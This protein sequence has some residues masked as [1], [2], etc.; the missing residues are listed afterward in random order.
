MTLFETFDGNKDV[1]R[2][3]SKEDYYHIK[4]KFSKITKK[5]ETET[6]DIYGFLSETEL[7]DLLQLLERN[8]LAIA[9]MRGEERRLALVR[10]TKKHKDNYN[11]LESYVEEQFYEG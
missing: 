2:W 4:K 11:K 7:Y 10:I 9:F 1:F 6:D 8:N 5:T 3:V